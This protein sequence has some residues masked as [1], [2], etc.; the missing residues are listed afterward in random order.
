[1][2]RPKS[3]GNAKFGSAATV[4]K[5]YGD[6]SDMWIHRKIADHGFPAPQTFGTATRY[7]LIE[8]LDRWDAA[9]RDR[10]INAPKV[11]PP[12]KAKVA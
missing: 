10:A 7:W 8:E 6:V 2:P 4:K 1:M 5:R 11:K 3:T 12:A 9:M